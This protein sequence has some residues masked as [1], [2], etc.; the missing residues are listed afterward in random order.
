M[1][2]P[3]EGD[4]VVYIIR[5][6]E[7]SEELGR[8]A[9][10]ADFE[11][12]G[13]VA[14]GDGKTLRMS[15]GAL[16]EDSMVVIEARKQHLDRDG[17]ERPSMAILDRSPVILVRPD[18][19]PALR[20][21]LVLDGAH[22]RGAVQVSGGQAGVY[23]FLRKAPDGDDLG[24]PAYFHKRDYDD[25][26]Q[27]KGIGQLAIGIDGA[28][29]RAG[30]TR[31]ARPEMPG[32]GAA[33][34][35]DTL[36]VGELRTAQ[37]MTREARAQTAP[38]SPIVLIPRLEAGTALHAHAVKAMTGLSASVTRTGT[39]AALPAISI[40]E[41]IVRVPDTNLPPGHPDDTAL[42]SVRTVR[43]AVTESQVGDS[44]QLMRNGAAIAPARD[45]NGQELSFSI[46]GP[47]EDT[48]FDLVISR[49]GDPGIAVV[50]VVRIAV[51]GAGPDLA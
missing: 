22:T 40:D 28:V 5:P 19:A 30:W 51:T 17:A 31:L 20:F 24:L 10:D 8:S 9:L 39:I 44:Y 3:T 23:Y 33:E 41:Q 49:P 48:V 25:P 35:G 14:T 32:V 12:I 2:I 45:G 4:R 36:M 46:P 27:N 43:I 18:P 1:A 42:N 11:P 21:E 26:A 29:R 15:L 6:A 50:R 38:L 47:G 13:P 7:S 16:A 34:L 37:S